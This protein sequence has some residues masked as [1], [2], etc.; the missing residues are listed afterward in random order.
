MFFWV[1]FRWW[2]RTVDLEGFY[3][4]SRISVYEVRKDIVQSVTPWM[5]EESTMLPLTIWKLAGLGQASCFPHLSPCDGDRIGAHLSSSSFSLQF[6]DFP[7]TL[8]EIIY[9][10]YKAEVK[11]VGSGFKFRLRSLLA[12]WPWASRF[13]SSNLIFPF[14]KLGINVSTR[15]PHCRKT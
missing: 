6:S 7:S 15:Y 13:T 10:C 2:I 12:E 1:L 9:L 4:R 3:S 5:A 8:K 14:C 11:N